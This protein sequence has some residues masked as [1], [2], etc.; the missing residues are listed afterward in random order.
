MT[1]IIKIKDWINNAENVIIGAGAGLS[2]AAGIHYT[3]EKFEHDFKDWI[4]KYGIE[5]LYTS[6]FY[7]FKTEEEKWAYW[8]KHIYFSYYERKHTELYRKLYDLVKNKNYFVITTNTDG[9]FINNG[10]DQEKV[11]EVQGSYSKLQCSIPCHNKL[12]YNEEHIKEMLDNIDNDL[13]IPSA[14]VPKCPVCGKNMSVNL[15]CDNT[16]VEDDNWNLMQNRYDNFIK[17]KSDKNLLLLEFG[18]GFNTPGIIR[19]PFE[20]MTYIHDN[21]K[22]IRFNDK[23]SDIPKGIQDRAISANDDIREIIDLLL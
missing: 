6:S 1:D 4:K 2:D 20:Q 13:K 8:A 9:Q 12:Y 14:L 23:Y 10:F 16:F 15:R 5:D 17:N 22:L 21:F 7:P 3:G 18:I 11:F 19:F